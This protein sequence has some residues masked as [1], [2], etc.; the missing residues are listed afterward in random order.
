MSR[1]IDADALKEK[2]GNTAFLKPELFKKFYPNKSV[3]KMIKSGQ[4]QIGDYV[5]YSGKG[6]HIIWSAGVDDE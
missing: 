3:P 6:Y 2:I 1:Y 4:I 5:G